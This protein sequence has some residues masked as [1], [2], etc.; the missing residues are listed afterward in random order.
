MAGFSLVLE[1]DQLKEE[2]DR[3][4]FRMAHSKWA[5]HKEFGSVVGLYP[6]DQD[7]LPVFSRDAELFVGTLEELKFWLHG[8]EWARKY[9]RMVMGKLNDKKRERKEQDYRNR[10]LVRILTKG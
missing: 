3:L 2:C 5:S 1:I 10:E 7:A 4:G 6:K 9:D 8:V